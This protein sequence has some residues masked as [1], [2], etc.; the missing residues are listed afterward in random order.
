MGCACLATIVR[1][2][3][4]YLVNYLTRLRKSIHVHYQRMQQQQEKEISTQPPMGSDWRECEALLRLVRAGGQ[5][6]ECHR[7]LCER[8]ALIGAQ[9]LTA[10]H[11]DQG[12]CGSYCVCK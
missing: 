8:L 1:P 10:R 3:K 11:T 4:N 12:Y 5:L 9:L 6:Y 7:R 2:L